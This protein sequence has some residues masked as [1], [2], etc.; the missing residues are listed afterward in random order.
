MTNRYES[1][2]EIIFEA[3]CKTAIDN[4]VLKERMRKAR[5]S[6]WEQSLAVLS[7]AVLYALSR[8]EPESEPEEEAVMFRVQERAIPVCHRELGQALL[9]LLPRDREIVLLY[10]FEDMKDEE[11]ARTIAV[12]RA[13]VQRRR[14]AAVKKLKS[15]LEVGL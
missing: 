5:R 9:Y 3:Y 12:G 2:N 10:Y 8:E 15:L 14:N 1:F 4:A 13:T 11:I 6:Q 7:D